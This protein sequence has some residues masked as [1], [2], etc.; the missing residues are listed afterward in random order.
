MRMNLL[1]YVN[2]IITFWNGGA[3]KKFYKVHIYLHFLQ[4]CDLGALYPLQTPQYCK[5]S[6]SSVVSWKIKQITLSIYYIGKLYFFLL[7]SIQ[8]VHI[9]VHDKQMIENYKL[10]TLRVT[11]KLKSLVFLQESFLATTCLYNV[12]SL[13][14]LFLWY[15]K[16]LH[17]NNILILQF[18]LFFFHTNLKL[19]EVPNGRVW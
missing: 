6:H 10:L 12:G 5:Y 13:Q 1:K 19:L 17:L 8:E 16:C 3:F 14:L 9:Q 7:V 4:W 18:T 2:L 11:E 15:L